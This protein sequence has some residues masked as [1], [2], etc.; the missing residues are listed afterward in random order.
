[1]NNIL[2]IGMTNRPDMLDEALLRSGRMD[3]HLKLS[4][5]D[6]KGRY[7]I[8][9]VH[10]KALCEGDKLDESVAL[11]ELA[12]LTSNFSGADLES[13]VR[14]AVQNAL[15]R[16]F[17]TDESGTKLVLKKVNDISELTK[18]TKEDFQ[19][20][21]EKVN[22]IYGLP[23]KKIEPYTKR[24]NLLPF[25]SSTKR[26]MQI[27]SKY[28]HTLTKTEGCP[29]LSILLW[30]KEA[31]GKTTLAAEMAVLSEA[32]FVT[33]I[34]AGELAG[35]YE[36]DRIDHIDT[37][38]NKA[39]QSKFSV[40]ISDNLEGILGASPLDR[41]SFS[42][43]TLLK[44]QELLKAPP[45][46]KML[47]LAT[48]GDLEFVQDIRLKKVFKSCVEIKEITRVREV[49]KLFELLLPEEKTG[50]V[51]KDD[52]S[53]AVEKDGDEIGAWIDYDDDDT[54]DLLPRPLPIGDIIV[55]M[56]SFQ[57]AQDPS[58]PVRMQDFLAYLEEHPWSP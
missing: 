47:V 45:V 51:E 50:S 6:E 41:R 24:N 18:V 52:K 19:K 10:T 5:P 2:V 26:V 13:L 57:A 16:N 31:V 28:V 11:E 14:K 12:E 25:N 23:T 29:T 3:V 38:F 55:E 21:F 43:Q 34:Q 8:L 54:S 17:E 7:D 42:I 27:V 30:G 4:L 56:K 49:A 39:Y 37:E 46:T 20:A 36:R 53:K 40:V 44:L 32:P 58:K 48:T 35:K 33:M 1:L 15:P 9:K 22:P